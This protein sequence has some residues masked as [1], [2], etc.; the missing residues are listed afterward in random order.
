MQQGKSI[1]RK[2]VFTTWLGVIVLAVCLVSAMT[3][4]MYSL[5]DTILLNIL[6][7]MAKTAAKSVEGNLHTLADRFF[8]IRSS[9]AL[10]AANVTV[11]TQKSALDKVT[12]GIEFEWLGI[13][14]QNGALIAGNENCPRTIAGRDLF[15]LL[16]ETSN[17]AIEET[18]VGN[19]GLEII[20]GVPMQS[21]QAGVTNY[22]AGSYNYDVLSD[23]LSNI[24][25]G[26]SG[27]AFI[28]DAKGRV[29]AHKDLGQVY[30]RASIT[31]SFG[32]SEKAQ[33]LIL[34]MKQGQTGSVEIMSP[35][36]AAF[37]SYAPIRGTRWSLGI[38]VPR[39]NFISPVQQAVFTSVFI[40]AILLL[41]FA[42]GSKAFLTK[43]LTEPLLAITDS[44]SKLAEGKFETKLPKKLADRTD[45]IGQLSSAFVKMSDSIRDVIAQIGQLTKAAQIGALNER[46]DLSARQGDYYLILAGMN[47]TMDVICSHLDAM[48]GAF[49]LFG[50]NR[51][52][53][54]L[55]HEMQEIFAVHGL[56]E[57]GTSPL[58]A[59]VCPDAN[60]VLDFE[61]DKLFGNESKNGDTYKKDVILFDQNG[62]ERDYALTLRRIGEQGQDNK[63]VCVMLIASDVTTLT[64]A[65]VAAEM[66]SK[67][68][69]NF[70]SSMSHEMRTPM[71]AII[72]MTTIA[73][74]S[75][76]IERKDYCLGKIDAASTHLLGVI[77]DILDMSK[78]EANKFE[79][80][81]TA[82]DFEKMLQKVI[83]VINFRV[84]EKQQKFVVHVDENIPPSLIGDDQ[85]LTQVITNLLSNATKFTPEGGKVKLAARMLQEN[86]G[87][88][89]IQ[90]DVTDTG[91]GISAEQQA[92]LFSSFEQAD[93]GTSRKYGGTGLGLAISK[94][95]IEMMDG[96][97]WVQSKLGEGATFSFTI[98]AKR[99]TNEKRGL[100]KPGR[101]WKNVRVLAVDDEPEI[102]E[103]FEEIAKRLG[104]TC[105][106]AASGEE[107]CAL[108]E[109]KGGYDIYFIDWKMPGMNGIELSRRI[110]EGHNT[111]SVVIM[112]S[113][114]EW[115]FIEDDAKSAGVDKFLPKP[116]FISEV[117]DII[118]QCLGS[119]NLPKRE[120]TAGTAKDAF[121]GYR[122]I[123]A[124]D[125]EINREIVLALL[126][127]TDLQIDIAETGIE[128]LQLF[129]GNPQDYD[130][131]FMDIHMPEMDGYEATRKIRALNTPYAQQIPIVAMTANVFREDIEKCLEAGM[132]DHVGKPLDFE[133]V[134][135]KLHKYLPAKNKG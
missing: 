7:P 78:I 69:S 73:R 36:G 91:I 41:F 77:N 134:L 106:V 102:R 114:T 18:S 51:L 20:M 109:R 88:C 24:N 131:I 44:A 62:D 127:P 103:Y 94:H 6:Q 59:I 1:T 34:T 54:Y 76:S 79:L 58:A 83:N 48:P 16:K 21:T 135:S 74:S 128:A 99:G 122:I 15:G 84:D 101:D 9:S 50:E 97:I 5:T 3:F 22:L 117:A 38:Q 39:S 85:R 43:I 66:A 46:V 42:I 89:T 67:A 53:I 90:I 71:N 82:F 70:L 121:A 49:A 105:E 61:V 12:A 57:K 8:L 125:V 65:R 40:T 126:A 55:N 10:N 112:I 14:S 108:I 132:N 68:K 56:D 81:P 37:V 92:R 107:A 64:N 96:R 45:E 72:G 25:I 2:I 86:D 118:N 115:S 130:M 104:L 93:S 80:S 123:L 113:A 13:Y 129:T 98:Q 124:E 23:V 29:I 116:L 111:Q 87:I 63:N 11:E 119:D 19:S 75:D 120:V 60:G 28:I 33:A 17:L 27:T 47:A 32:E 35:D 26:E 4:F 30:S 110:K 31:G 52:P 133:E 95:I 100:L